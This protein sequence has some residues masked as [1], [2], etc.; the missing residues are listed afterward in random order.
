LTGLNNRIESDIQEGQ[1]GLLQATSTVAAAESTTTSLSSVIDDLRRENESLSEQVNN[2]I[3][4]EN[5][6]ARARLLQATSAAASTE[7]TVTSLRSVIEELRRKNE[8]LQKQL[9]ESRDNISEE[10]QV[11]TVPLTS[12]SSIGFGGVSTTTGSARIPNGYRGLNWGNVKVVHRSRHPRSGYEYGTVS[13]DYVACNYGGSPCSISSTTPF[14]VAGF[15]ATAAWRLGLNVLVE[16]FD[17]SGNLIDSYQTTLGH[18][19]NGPTSID[20]RQEGN[21]EGLTKLK[22]TSSGGTYLGLGKFD[23]RLAIGN[24]IVY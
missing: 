1:A 24:M 5:Q 21:F 20:L 14:S 13:G 7:S 10:Q 18:P 15:Q 19:H 16:S 4:S 6:E 8:S 23:T 17:D 3:E 11:D 2:R 22:I 9:D 12:T